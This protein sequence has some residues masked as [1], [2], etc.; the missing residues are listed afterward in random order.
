MSREKKEKGNWRKWME[1][2][3]EINLRKN[4]GVRKEKKK[5]EEKRMKID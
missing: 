3:S 4:K 2:E 1:G 5:K